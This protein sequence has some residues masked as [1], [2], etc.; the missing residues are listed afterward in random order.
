METPRDIEG[1]MPPLQID[2]VPINADQ[3]VAE[4]VVVQPKLVAARFFEM[5]E[6]VVP[7]LAGNQEWPRTTKA[8]QFFKLIQELM[9]KLVN[10]RLHG[11]EG[12]VNGVLELVQAREEMLARAQNEMQQQVQIMN[13][14]V[15]ALAERSTAEEQ[16]D[17]QPSSTVIIP[18]FSKIIEEKIAKRLYRLKNKR[19]VPPACPHHRRKRESLLD[20]GLFGRTNRRSKSPS[21]RPDCPSA[22][23]P[24]DSYALSGNVEGTP[25]V[26]GRIGTGR[27]V[28]NREYQLDETRLGKEQI[29]NLSIT[30]CKTIVN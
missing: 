12:Q 7:L 10:E 19:D 2:W 23:S 30:Y 24:S 25:T 20:G 6:E 18:D 4:A 29:V 3:S 22:R 11:I 5:P 13:N 17:W 14:Q 21:Y 9:V 15:L 27:A 26:T 1:A 8:N 16:M 28:R